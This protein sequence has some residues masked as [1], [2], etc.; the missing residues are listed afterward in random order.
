MGMRPPNSSPEARAALERP[1]VPE[2]L[3]QDQR[4][5]FLGPWRDMD[6]KAQWRIVTFTGIV[7]ALGFGAVFVLPGLAFVFG[8]LAAEIWDCRQMTA[9]AKNPAKIEYLKHWTGAKIADPAFLEE[10]GKFGRGFQYPSDPE[11]FRK[12]ELDLQSVGIDPEHFGLYLKRRNFEDYR[13]PD[14]IRWVVFQ[15]HN[16]DVVIK[17]NKANDISLREPASN[18]D[19]TIV[20]DEVSVWCRTH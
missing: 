1:N 14:N 9:L 12:H 5:P 20:N 11:K 8:L 16:A 7:A 13:D 6:E 3:V 18:E 10:Y 15:I 17:I 2:H 4:E 19:A